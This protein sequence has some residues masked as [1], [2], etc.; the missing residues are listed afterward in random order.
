MNCEFEQAFF[1]SATGNAKEGYQLVS[2]SKGLSSPLRDRLTG[3]GPTHDAMA[4]ADRDSPAISWFTLPGEKNVSWRVLA[5][6]R[7]ESAEYSGRGG[8]CTTTRF[9]LSPE[10]TWSAFHWDPFRVVD[11]LAVR[12][13]K[14]SAPNGGNSDEATI[15]LLCTRSHW[16]RGDI[17]AE[18]S[19]LLGAGLVASIAGAI[20]GG[21]H[22][23]MTTKSHSESIVR[24]LVNLLPV[25]ARMKL[26]FTTGLRPTQQRPLQLHVLPEE[27]ANKSPSASRAKERN[28]VIPS[29]SF[30][31]PDSGWGREL[32]SLLDAGRWSA[33]ADL[34]GA[35]E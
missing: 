15:V 1:T 32:H 18:S 27:T 33:A 21:E 25:A 34:V 6:T 24:S 10:A 13:E 22:I 4:F 2:A 14:S 5:I 23:S 19:R 35:A 28:F 12:P 30:A 31:A 16:C 7:C 11:A 26:S 8:G 29:P 3:W 17:A 20:V 9:V